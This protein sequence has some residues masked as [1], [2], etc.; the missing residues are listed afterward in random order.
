[1]AIRTEKSKIFSA[2]IIPMTIDMIN[3]QHQRLA[4][5]NSFHSAK[6][7]AIRNPYF[8]HRAPQLISLLMMCQR[9]AQHKHLIRAYFFRPAAMLLPL[10]SSLTEKMV[11][12]DLKLLDQP[13]NVGL[14]AACLLQTKPP[15]HFGV[16]E[17]RSNN[18][19]QQLRIIFSVRHTS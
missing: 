12:A 19:A 7:A 16:R 1:M 5:P 9:I 13:F 18:L 3:R 17:R 14:R 4:I 11:S 10:I 6:S 15:E 8:N 2:V